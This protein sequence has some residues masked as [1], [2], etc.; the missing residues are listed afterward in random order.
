[1]LEAL[2]DRQSEPL[3]RASLHVQS[4]LLAVASVGLADLA[5]NA[6]GGVPA[7]AAVVVAILFTFTGC[8]QGTRRSPWNPGC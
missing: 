8:R 7:L 5:L 6:D 4:A 1:M 2:Y 3:P